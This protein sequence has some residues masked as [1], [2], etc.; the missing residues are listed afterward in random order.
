MNGQAE[1]AFKSG[2]T[3]PVGAAV[4]KRKLREKNDKLVASGVGGMIKRAP[5]Y[6]PKHGDWEYFYFE[7]EAKIESGKIDSCVNC[8]RLAAKTDFVFGNWGKP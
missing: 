6:D 7:D 4:V 3:Y 1:A 8:H 5:G 2:G